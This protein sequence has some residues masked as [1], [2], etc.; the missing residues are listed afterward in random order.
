[1]PVV[2][3]IFE[4]DPQLITALAFLAENDRYSVFYFGRMIRFYFIFPN[5]DPLSVYL[6]FEGIEGDLM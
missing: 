1:M 5:H 4:H 3:A 2:P 6:S